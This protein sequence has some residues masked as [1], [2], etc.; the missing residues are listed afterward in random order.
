MK[1]IYI[2]IDPGKSGAIVALFPDDAAVSKKWTDEDEMSDLVHSFTRDDYRILAVIEEVHSSPQMGV[3][4]AFTFGQN[5]GWWLGVLRAYSVPFH[6]IRPQVWQAGIPGRKGLKE[7]NLKR[8][9][10]SEAAA[11]YPS[12]K[13]TLANA[14][15]LLIADWAR[16]K[17]I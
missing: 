17:G 5:F 16:M 7:G 3:K 9:L 14:D 8:H 11:R 2:G 13:V 10:K 12:I 6:R 4:S 1:T 15:A